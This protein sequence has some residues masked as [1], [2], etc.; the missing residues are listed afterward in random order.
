MLTEMLTEME[1]A[2]ARLT[3]VVHKAR[4]KIFKE[5]EAYQKDPS[6]D[7]VNS[8]KTLSNIVEAPFKNC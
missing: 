6:P 4:E 3:K 5:W 1:E 8:I 2:E 7:Q